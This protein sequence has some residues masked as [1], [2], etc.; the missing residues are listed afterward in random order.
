[1]SDATAESDV[2][3]RWG[4][5]VDL[6]LLIYSMF[7][8]PADLAVNGPRTRKDG[9]ILRDMLRVIEFLI[10]RTLFLE[11]ID[12]GAPAAARKPSKHRAGT[13]A[14]AESDDPAAWRLS[15]A[16]LP[17]KAC[18]TTGSAPH[19]PPAS[20]A[21]E[22]ERYL[23]PSWEIYEQIHGPRPAYTVTHYFSHRDRHKKRLA[24]KT[25]PFRALAR[26]LEALARVVRKPARRVTALA[27]RLFAPNGREVAHRILTMPPRSR[28]DRFGAYAEEVV[29][30]CRAAYA[31]TYSDSS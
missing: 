20:G 19:R 4:V 6:I 30:P 16:V 21:R 27:R 11:A 9:D 12:A 29:A 25:L 26:R 23:M 2:P 14:G 28:Y 31:T 18:F 1:M 22:E 3:P 24:P 8:R 7:G 13:K 17:A 10:R 15:F 5:I